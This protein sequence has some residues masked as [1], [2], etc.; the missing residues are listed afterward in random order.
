MEQPVGQG[1]KGGK[2]QGVPM[3]KR[4]TSATPR[5][6]MLMEFSGK[7]RTWRTPILRGKCILVLLDCDHP[8]RGYQ[9]CHCEKEGG[10][11]EGWGP[12]NL[13]EL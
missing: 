7:A 6:H 8:G 3:E 12:K 13:R 10:D 9:L 5:P 1:S 2:Y 11:Q 4:C